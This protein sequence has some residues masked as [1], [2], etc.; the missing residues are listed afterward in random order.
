MPVS[1]RVRGFQFVTGLVAEAKW[2]YICGRTRTKVRIVGYM[3]PLLLQLGKW[4]L[5]PNQSRE[6][7]KIIT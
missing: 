4:D 1:L 6:L 3:F 7:E 2:H 5:A